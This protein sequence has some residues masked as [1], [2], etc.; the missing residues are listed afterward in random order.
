MHT[1]THTHWQTEVLSF[2]FSNKHSSSRDK[3][4]VSLQDA[5]AWLKLDFT[6]SLDEAN[7]YWRY[8][9]YSVARAQALIEVLHWANGGRKD[10]GNSDDET[11]DSDGDVSPDTATGD[12]KKGAPKKVP[13]RG[14]VIVPIAC[15]TLAS[16][17]A[18]HDGKIQQMLRQR[19]RQK[20]WHDELSK[21]CSSE[22][23]ISRSW[24]LSVPFIE[25]LQ[26]ETSVAKAHEN[27]TRIQQE[28]GIKPHHLTRWL[29]GIDEIGQYV[30]DLT[31][32]HRKPHSLG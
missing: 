6:V 7:E 12:G 15:Q 26:A 20:V 5:I 27:A 22:H 32:W 10:K 3:W 4:F 30:R 29:L 9:R 19:F 13:V 17:I 14:D 18:E 25:Q 8:R 16:V 2:Y 11:D 23:F 21:S 31:H 1:R 28:W 24:S